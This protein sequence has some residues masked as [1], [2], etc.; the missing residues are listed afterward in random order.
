[1]QLDI[2]TQEIFDRMAADFQSEFPEINVL[3]RGSFE[4]GILVAMSRRFSESY[5][6][7]RILRQQLFVDTAT[8][9][10]LE[11]R[12]SYRKITRIA[13]TSAAGFVTATGVVT[14]VIPINSILATPDGATFK[15]QAVATIT[16]NLNSV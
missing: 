13:A 10:S 16:A 1:M 6:Q 2:T 9:E 5:E 15:T 12:G 14:S 4:R 3:Q 11:R 7:L 8:G